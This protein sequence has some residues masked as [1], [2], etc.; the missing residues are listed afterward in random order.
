MEKLGFERPTLSA[1]ETEKR[2]ALSKELSEF[3]NILNVQYPLEYGGTKE[4]ILSAIA[5]FENEQGEHLQENT[6]LVEVLN[7]IKENI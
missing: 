1:S 5:K 3:V 2:L 7:K 4:E 6:K